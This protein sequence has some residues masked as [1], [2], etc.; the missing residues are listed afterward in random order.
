[1][2]TLKK[3]GKVVKGTTTV[4]KGTAKVVV[5]TAKVTT[6]I[7]KG[8]AE[9]F[10]NSSNS[11]E[12][13]PQKPQATPSS[14]NNLLA[15]TVASSSRPIPIDR[16]PSNF[17]KEQII[18]A[19]KTAAE[20]K[21]ILSGTNEAHKKNYQSLLEQNIECLVPTGEPLLTVPYS[22][23]QLDSWTKRMLLISMVLNAATNREQLVQR[24]LEANISQHLHLQPPHPRDRSL[25]EALLASTFVS[26]LVLNIQP[27]TAE[28]LRKMT[29]ILF[30]A[31]NAGLL[32]AP[33]TTQYVL[34]IMIHSDFG[35]WISPNHP[36]NLADNELL[37]FWNNL[38]PYTLLT[39][40][41]FMPVFLPQQNSR[42]QPLSNTTHK[43]IVD[44]L[45]RQIVLLAQK[46]QPRLDPIDSL[47]LSHCLNYLRTTA[48][49]QAEL[50]PHFTELLQ[51][52]KHLAAL[53]EKH[54]M[55]IL[56]TFLAQKECSPGECGRTECSRE[57]CIIP[58]VF[59]RLDA[60][61]STTHQEP[62]KPLELMQIM[63][64]NELALKC[65]IAFISQIAAQDTEY[66]RLLFIEFNSAHATST[67]SVNE[68][69]ALIEYIHEEHPNLMDKT[70]SLTQKM[71]VY[72]DN[73]EVDLFSGTAVQII[74]RNQAPKS[75]R[76]EACV[77]L[78]HQI[79]MGNMVAVTPVIVGTTAGETD[80]QRSIYAYQFLLGNDSPDA[81]C[82][83]S[84]YDLILS[85]GHIQDI[86]E[87]V[88]LWKPQILRLL[89]AFYQ[90]PENILVP[91]FKF[92][93]LFI[94]T[95]Q[96]QMLLLIRDERYSELTTELLDIAAHYDPELFKLLVLGMATL[97]VEEQMRC[98]I[99]VPHGPYS[100]VLFYVAAQHPALFKPVIESVLQHP[101]AEQ[102]SALFNQE[103]LHGETSLTL[104]SLL[105]SE[106]QLSQLIKLDVN[107]NQLDTNLDTLLHHAIKGGNTYLA[108]KLL[109]KDA[110][111]STKNLQQMHALEIAIVYQP[112]LIT[113]I[114]FRLARLSLKEQT[115]YLLNLPDAFYDVVLDDSEL[116]N[117]LITLSSFNHAPELNYMLTAMGLD[118]H[119]QK[120]GTQY[121]SMKEKSR[122]NVRY[123]EAA[124]ATKTL[125]V[126]CMKAK[127]TLFQNDAADDIK[128]NA[129]KQRYNNAI[130]TARTVLCHY[131]E[132]GK[133]LACAALPVSV[134]LYGLGL[135]SFKTKSEQALDELNQQ[136][137]RLH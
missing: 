118:T 68:K 132:W 63:G 94:E 62:L 44:K 54:Q 120:L 112:R 65:Q 72:A 35:R 97:S 50:T 55:D 124:S 27:S 109:D 84:L 122:T 125:L 83:K 123:T 45:E 78:V 128:I 40:A 102:V 127:I 69:I 32:T 7:V 25:L 70:Q 117:V 31:C 14:S 90:R 92:K 21:I 49:R 17:Y 10:A 22:T 89:I 130:E 19:G 9:F 53:D 2:G 116:T 18:L 4:V 73:Q 3:L 33:Q 88:P 52:P 6:K 79:A 110:D 12:Q 30:A 75:I 100:N 46:A 81:A 64:L 13:L 1:M 108:K 107:I 131:R 104:V 82:F 99:Y 28:H 48:W 61:K 57:G 20:L 80:L 59:K 26:I 119:L 60:H 136:V 76:D 95:L 29:G 85:Q 93:R 106:E 126:E 129:F 74:H 34:T 24:L 98:L 86:H 77:N 105:G 137:M 5:G 113:P 67:L 8:T 121:L 135:F 37:H 39:H 87:T 41:L 96:K 42:L 111:I 103:T 11:S 115:E 23:K 43:F 38:A 134:A 101:N 51:A 56:I 71:T 16:S 15:D 66:G 36:E 47:Q 133:W 91:Q 114:L 58:Y